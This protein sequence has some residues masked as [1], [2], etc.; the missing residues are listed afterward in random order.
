M[1]KTRR[2]ISRKDFLGLGG[3]G[4]AGAAL[5][6]TA[7]C[8]GGGSQGGGEVVKYFTGT[9]ETSSLERAAIEIQVDGFQ[10]EN[11]KYT[12]EREAVPTEDQRSVIQTRLQSND[13]PDVFS[14]DTGPASAASW[15]MRGSCSP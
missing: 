10:K 7:G 13:P 5:L 4:L 3:A 12:L 6:G 15:R 2:A 11:P 9:A 14:Y 8:G 1:R